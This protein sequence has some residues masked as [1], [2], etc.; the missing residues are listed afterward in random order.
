MPPAARQT[1]QPGKPAL[2]AR[3]ALTLERILSAAEELLVDR[4]FDQLSVA[5]IAA[6]AGGAVGTVYGRVA[7]KEDLLFCLH[8]R[9]TERAAERVAETFG[10]LGD[11]GLE[12]RVEALC[13]LMVGLIH[14]HRG[15]GRAMT[16]RLYTSPAHTPSESM[17]A[18]RKDATSMFRS[19]AAFLAERMPGGA[20][21]ENQ[22][23][24][25]FALLAA[26]DVTQSRIVYGS[27]SGLALKYS[28]QELKAR[29]TE[30]VLRYLTAPIQ[31]KD[32]ESSDA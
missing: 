30:L 10:G 25:E 14:D 7:D 18:F 3:S 15:I 24:C 20:N 13:H 4:E 23:A 28:Q 19:A 9:Y 29:T 22:A 6:K 17:S 5:E 26:Q 16:N 12:A 21:A 31:A 11:A 2:Q 8:E 32:L 27:R 1:S